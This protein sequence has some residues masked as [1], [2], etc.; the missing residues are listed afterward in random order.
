MLLSSVPTVLSMSRQKQQNNRRHLDALASLSVHK[1]QQRVKVKCAASHMEICDMLLISCR[2]MSFELQACQDR[3]LKHQ[4]RRVRHGP[5]CSGQIDWKSLLSRI[6][7]GANIVQYAVIAICI[8]GK[9]FRE[10]ITYPCSPTRIKTQVIVPP[11]PAVQQWVPGC[12]AMSRHN[13]TR[14]W[15]EGP[16]SKLSPVSCFELRRCSSC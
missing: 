8:K 9:A 11:G 7:C 6:E 5:P 1:L 12:H 15:E 13:G 4:G 3:T 14:Y 16:V 10:Q 2:R